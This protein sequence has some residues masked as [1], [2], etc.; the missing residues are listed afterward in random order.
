MANTRFYYD[1]AR[2]IKRLQ[3][4][5]GPGRYSLNMPGNGCTPCFVE[6]PHIRL[7]EWGA[8]LRSVPNHH[9]VDI[10][11]DLQGLTRPLRKY[12]LDYQKYSVKSSKR[13][14]PECTATYTDESR[15]THPAWQYK[16]MG[17]ARWEYPVRDPQQ[18]AYMKFANNLNSSLIHSDNY[19]PK[20]PCRLE[21]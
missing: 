18:H 6:D 11:S 15:A 20:V 5:T 2:T 16:G 17:E 9:P 3:Q 14:F 1:N 19:V 10:T 8:N 7:Q 4:S 12:S 13:S 21:K